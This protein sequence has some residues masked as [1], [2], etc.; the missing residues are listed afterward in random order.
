M[1]VVVRSAERIGT[2]LR[3]T[4]DRQGVSVAELA[5]RTGKQVDH[6]E[7]VL[8]GYPNSKVRPTQLDTVGEIAEELHLRLGV[9][10]AE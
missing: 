5:A 1:E 10:P 8:Q 7:A 4:M 6:I 3:E 2:K 9:V